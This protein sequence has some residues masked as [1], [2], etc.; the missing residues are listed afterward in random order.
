MTASLP[1]G[2]LR[3]AATLVPTPG[4]VLHAQ[5]AEGSAAAYVVSLLRSRDPRTVVLIV[6]T[7]EEALRVLDDLSTYAPE[8]IVSYLP[9]SE[10]TPYDGSRP[11]RTVTLSR[12]GTL[13]L[14]HLGR[15][16]VLLTTA[17]GWIRR[18]APADLLLSGTVRLG[19]GQPIDFDE[20]SRR[21]VA[22]GYGRAPVVEDPGT[23]AVRGDILDVWPPTSDVP[24]RLSVNFEVLE[25]AR[26]YNPETQL[27]F[28]EA[29]LSAK[30]LDASGTEIIVSP[31]RE[32]VL[33]ESS[34]KRA[35]ETMQSLCDL[36]SLPTKKARA[37]IEDVSEGHLF[38][39]SGGYLPAYSELVGLSSQLPDDSLIV[40][41]EPDLVIDEVRSELEQVR[42]AEQNAEEQPHFPIESHYLLERDLDETIT[43][44]PVL[45]LHRSAIVGGDERGFFSLGQ[46]PEG[47]P[48][49]AFSSQDEL[50]QKLEA[51]RKSAGRS[52][53]LE[54]LSRQ[55]RA[56]HEE[57]FCVVITARINTQAERLA[58]LLEHRELRPTSGSAALGQTGRGGEL[59]V[60][61]GDLSRGLIAP[62]EQIV[63]LTEE[64]I[65]GRRHHG[66]KR[67]PQAALAAV[68][69]DLRS[70]SLGDFVVHVEHGIGRYVGLEHRVVGESMVELLVVEY[71]GGD[72]LML[73]VYRLNQIQKF[74]GEAAPRLDRLGGQTFAK[75]KATVKK[76]AR[77]IA[78]RL[79]KLYAERKAVRRDPIDPPGDDFAA[80]E[81]SF[82][83]DETPDQSA[84]IFD[85]VDD[86]RK[87]TVMDR[88][89]CGDVGF[90]KTEVALRATFLSAHMGR[91]VALLCPTT[92]LAEQHLRTFKKRFEE[93]G[94]QVAGLSR[95]QTK[96]AQDK[97][98][99]DLREGKIDVVIGTHRLLSK[100]VYF[101]NLGLLIVDEEQRFGVTHKERLKELRRAVDVL[102]LSATPIP[103]TLNL[104]VGGLRDMSV[105][106]TAPQERRSIRTITSRF[107]ERVIETAVRREL[108]RGG[109]VYYVHNRVEGIYERAELL[110]RLV[111]EARIAV[112][113]GQMTERALEKAM[114][115]FVDGQFDVLCATAIVESGL[116][117][118]DANTIIIDRAD[119]FGL[120]QLYQIRGRVG[121]SSERAYCYL[122]V[123]SDARLTDEAR[124]RISALERYTEL[125]SGFHIAT[126]DMEIRGA[127]EL[128]GADQSGFTAK[129]GFELFSQMLEEA[130]ADLRGE[131]YITEVDPELSI[132]VEALLPEDYIE[133]IGIRLSLY[134]RYALCRS[135]EEIERLDEELKNRFGSAPPAARR[136]SEVMR[137]KTQL[138]RL[139]ALGLSASSKNATMHL[140]DDTPLSP[141][142]LVPL[143]ERSAGGYRLTP[144]GRL[145][146]HS[147]TTESGLQHA[148]K[149][150]T[151]LCELLEVT[152]VRA[153]R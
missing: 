126:M 1:S 137:I 14:L 54:P 27:T 41:H 28:K 132:D 90:G 60:T 148:R 152:E 40:I 21:L 51:A 131:Q 94:I 128:L 42:Q 12:A 151:E 64:E 75:T 46:A 3:S 7:H 49:L 61:T 127:G 10:S 130:A 125:G 118:P 120:S 37:L 109:Q 102:T 108:D 24:V 92:V 97:T 119:L 15:L 29:D 150:V 106:A 86:L 134:K 2:A 138:R 65:F 79:L 68:L 19:I 100:D 31:A 91:Q 149:M 45:C 143:I 84:A 110:R 9:A 16:D 5:G 71:Y 8:A 55:I 20:V 33:T 39:G 58:H 47:C 112:G 83:H 67:K 99:S 6:K 89:V 144:D 72:K 146:R 74:S 153:A 101:K 82:P 129:V 96:K 105:I 48:Q 44:R 123:P 13:S 81:A 88:L 93:T 87:E 34:R 38:I 136:F 76:K 141:D 103:R 69:D 66:V 107:D 111:P 104:A 18:V 115:G 63:F 77:Q 145:T 32:S 43:G 140:R 98:L 95:F 22:G 25:S 133:D 117:I 114:L 26:P 80:F 50:A 85:V 36:V 116:D 121:R 35:A 23:F 62:L 30:V 142:R 17:R 11:D 124:S 57:G 53:G 56:W 147:V 70:L 139:R 4:A 52:A 113:H 59:I 73:P 135:E 78:D 122:L